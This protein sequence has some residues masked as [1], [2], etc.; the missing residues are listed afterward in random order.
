MVSLPRKPGSGAVAPMYSEHVITGHEKNWSCVET[1]T[2]VFE[3][4]VEKLKVEKAA[5]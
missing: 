3:D 4:E 2:C 5:L 1:Q